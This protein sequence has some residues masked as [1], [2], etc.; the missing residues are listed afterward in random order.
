MCFVRRHDEDAELLDASPMPFVPIYLRPQEIDEAELL[1]DIDE[2]NRNA[3]EQDRQIAILNQ[4]IVELVAQLDRDGV[5]WEEMLGVAPQQP[6]P[7]QEDETDMEDNYG[8]D[9]YID[10]EH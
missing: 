4:A 3:L 6:R 5:N 8:D 9:D 2:I 1:R 10:V 7:E